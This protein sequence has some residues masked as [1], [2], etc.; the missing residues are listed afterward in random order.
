MTMKF[1]P[2]Q[3]R[4]IQAQ[5]KFMSDPDATRGTILCA[6]GGGKTEVFQDLI[7]KV[8]TAMSHGAARILVVHPRIALSQNQ[9]NRFAKT[10]AG[11]GIEFTN[12][13]SGQAKTHTLNDKKNV[14]TTDTNVLQEIMN[15]HNG[16]HITF[17][18]YKSL[19][20]IAAM[21]FD[22][23]ICDEAHYLVQSDLREN[24]HLFKSKTL[25]YTGTPVRMAAAEASMDNVELFGP[26]I[27]DV[28]PKE[29]IPNGYIVR[30]RIR[31]VNVLSTDNGNTEDYV[32]AIAAAFKD[33]L[34]FAHKD[35][36]HKMLVAMPNT[37]NFSDIANELSEIRNIV[38]NNDIDL[39]Y[40]TADTAVKNGS[41][42]MDRDA[43]VADFAKNPN[44][45]IIMHC[46]T[47]A[48]GIDV[49][50]IGGVLILRGLGM[51]KAIQ[52]IGR[53]CRAANADI[54]KS[55][56][57]A[58]ELRKNRIKTECIVT[59]ARFNGEWAG[60][61]NLSTYAAMFEQ[62][63]YDLAEFWADVEDQHNMPTP[64]GELMDRDDAIYKEA[65]DILVTEG[66]DALFWELFDTS[67]KE[68][69]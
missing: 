12:F 23:I 68:V 35:F 10:F 33:Q 44:P 59:I 11:M 9:Q 42:Q 55:G 51:V 7:M 8:V 19:H 40:V 41:L 25:F 31:T 29:L 67:A 32:S 53:G 66:Q 26:V 64:G 34:T 47:L 14:S 38:G 37:M 49:D 50:G 16:A 5:D 69:Q 39:Y 60:D 3:V 17:S 18:S 1:R 46:D 30:P 65:T 54:I 36:V 57:L 22:L 15:S 43:L 13:H 58:G 63:G 61:S 27:A 24:M 21:N 56:A 62:G 2:Y 52:T 45:S 20:R 48:E 4:M 28:S 6:T